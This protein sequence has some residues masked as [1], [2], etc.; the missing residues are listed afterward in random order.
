[1]ILAPTVHEC[2]ET[3]A[4]R[5]YWSLVEEYSKTDEI[6]EAMENDIEVLKRFLEEADI[7]A[8]RGETENCLSKNESPRVTVQLDTRGRLVVKVR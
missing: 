6:N 3:I 4:G 7:A 5:R 2:I 1:M 8:L